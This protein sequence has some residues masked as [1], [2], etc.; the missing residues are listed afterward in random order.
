VKYLSA[1]STLFL[2]S[3]SAI[4]DTTDDISKPFSVGIAT[5]ASV[6]AY[7]DA[8]LKDDEFSGAAL[9]FTY[10]FTDQFAARATFFSLE[11]NDISDIESKGYDFLGYL[12]TG[13]ATHGIKA[14]VGGGLFKDKWEWGSLSESHSGLQ[15]SGGIGYNWD[16]VSLDLV[17]GL[18][19]A[20]DYEDSINNSLFYSDVSA[21]AVSSSLL[22][23]ARF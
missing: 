19:S 22:L 1:L 6:I 7:D 2:L 8:T 20:K 13:L 18:R 17:L 9:S 5:Y 12:G 14:Y 11:H 23:S 16:F 10:A 4:A 21:A 3:S 15:L